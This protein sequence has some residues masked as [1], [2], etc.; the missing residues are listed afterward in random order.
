MAAKL[1][2][3]GVVDGKGPRASS[4]FYWS[5]GVRLELKESSLSAGVWMEAKQIPGSLRE[6]WSCF[7]FEVQVG[8]YTFLHLAPRLCAPC[9][10]TLCAGQQAGGSLGLQEVGAGGKDKCQKPRGLRHELGY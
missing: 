1:T 6:L 9:Q 7:C 5:L 10:Q 4:A 8:V 3:T 2:A